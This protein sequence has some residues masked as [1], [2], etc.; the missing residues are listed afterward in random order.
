MADDQ[1]PLR[2][3][4]RPGFTKDQDYG[5]SRTQG[6]LPVG[7]NHGAGSPMPPTNGIGGVTVP[8]IAGGMLGNNQAR[9]ATSMPADAWCIS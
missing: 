3:G 2:G 6:D 4:E 7:E 1:A 9:A 8:E 5:Y